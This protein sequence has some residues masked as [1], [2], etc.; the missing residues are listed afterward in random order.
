MS[1]NIAESKIHILYIVNKV[2]GVSYHMLMN[3]VMES[4]YLDFFSFGQAYKELVSGNLMDSVPVGTEGGEALGGTE[5]LEL[6][7]GGRAILSDLISTINNQTLAHLDSVAEALS[8]EMIHRAELTASYEPS[9]IGKYTVK[10]F[11][12][13]DGLPVSVSLTV[14]SEDDAKKICRTW[15]NGGAAETIKFF[16]TLKI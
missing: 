15:K 5:L 13:G 6:T 3:A 10:L 12:A 8:E 2:P 9:D 16:D 7:E 11:C 4:L 1:N 14:A